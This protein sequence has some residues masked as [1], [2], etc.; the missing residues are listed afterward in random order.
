MATVVGVGVGIGVGVG[1]VVGGGCRWRGKRGGVAHSQ[2]CRIAQA[3][4]QNAQRLQRIAGALFDITSL[5]PTPATARSGS[6]IAPSSQLFTPASAAGPSDEGLRGMSPRELTLSLDASAVAKAQQ[7]QHAREASP[8][9]HGTATVSASGGD[10]Q[11]SNGW[12]ESSDPLSASQR[13]A[14][15]VST[16][17]EQLVRELSME[18]ARQVCACSRVPPNN[19]TPRVCCAECGCFCFCFVFALFV[20]PR[21]G[22][23][24]SFVLDVCCLLVACCCFVCVPCHATECRVSTTFR[25]LCQPSCRASSP[26]HH[27]TG[28]L[29]QHDVHPLT[30]RWVGAPRCVHGRRACVPRLHPGPSAARTDAG[31]GG[32]PPTP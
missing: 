22:W 16:V 15:A 13:R 14:A 24:T 28:R 19:G 10:G 4:V 3:V 2:D 26:Q 29:R 11:Q 18:V 9:T 32:V 17:A 12:A 8:A 23:L 27:P 6:S 20:W 25:R 21:H 31:A 1:V 30:A 5:P 7:Q